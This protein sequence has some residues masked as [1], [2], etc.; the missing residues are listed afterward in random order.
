M[1]G[2]ESRDGNM[3]KVVQYM[4]QTTPKVDLKLNR[5]MVVG[6]DLL[7]SAGVMTVTGGA[8]YGAAWGMMGEAST[9]AAVSSIAGISL[10][11][12]SVPLYIAGS[13]LYV[14]GKKSKLQ[15]TACGLQLWF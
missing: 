13:V 1:K 7:I 9:I 11:G 5:Q 2:N 12:L 6:R 3:G 10:M 4:P 8:L 15:P 14:K